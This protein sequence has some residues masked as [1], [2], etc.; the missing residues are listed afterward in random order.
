MES[1][2]RRAS[3]PGV[4]P[5]APERRPAGGAPAVPRARRFAALALCLAGSLPAT[6]PAA[7]WSVSP[8]VD[9]GAVRDDNIR[10]T[11]GDH[12]TTSG[13]VAAA[14][15][16]LERESPTSQADFAATVVRTDY[17]SGE[18]DDR[19]EHRAR[20]DA[21]K[22]TSERGT[23]GLRGEY[24]RDTLFETVIFDPG[25]G[26]IRDVDVG[27][28]RDAEVRRYYRVLQP[29]WT[30][31]LT[32]LSG[33]DVSYR[34]SDVDFARA[35]GTDVVNY[36]SDLLTATYNRRLSL[37][38]SF[39]VT[40]AAARYRPESGDNDADTVQLLVG[41]GRDFSE[42]L[43]GSFSLGASRTREQ[44]AAE[45][46]SG[47]V[48]SGVLRQESEVSTLE[49]ILS[50]DVAPSGIGRAL[51]TDQLRIYWV[52]RLS[53]AT[54]F[55]L[56]AWWLQTEVTEG[57][58]PSAERRYYE[59][60]PQFRWRWLENVSVVASYSYRWQKYVAEPDSAHSNTVFLGLGYRL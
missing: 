59:I 48:V 18:A 13:Y 44:G 21:V 12:E 52:R 46:D 3:R 29:S 36:D 19:T 47:I 60:S 39:L 26:D 15:L 43:E 38:N 31:Q 11:P 33:L 57:F 35:E 4:A 41:M 54:D 40:A 25:V 27:L 1:K 16:E 6:A 53:P 32:E 14:N 49:G 28:A 51:Q 9:V 20:L 7:Q 37:Q 56:D 5:P 22:R 58:D 50:R 30:W 10:L 55:V 2:P 42:T 8:G 34:R 45:D 23:L 24:R 17:T